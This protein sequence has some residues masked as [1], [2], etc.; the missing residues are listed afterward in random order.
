[1]A[2]QQ[3]G[4]SHA[5]A[6]GGPQARVLGRAGGGLGDAAF[7]VRPAT[8]RDDPPAR[9]ALHPGANGRALPRIECTDWSSSG[10]RLGGLVLSEQDGEAIRL[11]E[12]SQPAG[13][14]LQHRIR[15]RRAVDRRHRV[16]HG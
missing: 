9:L 6:F 12:P 2:S 8:A 5:V 10:D 4:H 13:A 11:G 1:M 7:G 3:A 15:Q 16:G 14:G